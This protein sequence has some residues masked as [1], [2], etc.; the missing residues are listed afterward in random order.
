RELPPRRV[1]NPLSQTPGMPP[2]VARHLLASDQVKLLAQATAVWVRAIA[3]SPRAA[4][5]P[6]RTALPP[7]RAFGGIRLRCGKAA[8]DL[9][10]GVLLGAKEPGSSS[11][12]AGP[13]R[14][15]GWPSASKATLLPSRGQRRWLH[16]RARQADLPLARTAALTRGRLRLTCPGTRHEAL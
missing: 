12:S 10:H 1:L 11:G 8:L 14:G 6:T 4:C 16:T 13:E 7:L 2:P 15:T 5:R 3:S 9:G